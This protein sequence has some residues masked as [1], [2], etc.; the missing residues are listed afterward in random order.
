ME[1]SWS[2]EEMLACL[3][4]WLK[5]NCRTQQQQRGWQCIVASVTMHKWCGCRRLVERNGEICASSEGRQA[6]QS[7]G[8]IAGFGGGKEAGKHVVYVFLL[9]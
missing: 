4:A 7:V 9:A 2:D 8:G 5:L 6:G 1:S 3:R